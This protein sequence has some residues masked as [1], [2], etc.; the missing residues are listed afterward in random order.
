VRIGAGLLK[1][2]SAD[3]TL[4]PTLVVAEFESEAIALGRFQRLESALEISR[5][6]GIELLRRNSGGRAIRIGPGALGLL[7]SV[8]DPTAF[9]GAPVPPDKVINRFVRGLLAG[10]TRCG[11]PGGAH[12]FGR[13]FVSVQ[14]KQVA[15]VG[16][17]GS[18]R[19]ALFEAFVA[20]EQTLALPAGFN[21]Y[22]AHADPRAQGPE[23]VSLQVLRGKPVSFEAVAAAIV[24]GY[25]SHHRCELS[26]IDSAEMPESALDAAVEDEAGFSDSGV[27]EIPIGFLEA[28]VQAQA[29]KVQQARIRG[30]F[31][32]P[33]FAI[34]ELEKSL[35]DCPLS[36][37]ELGKRVDAAFHLPGA[38]VIGVQELRI[39][40]EAVLAAVQT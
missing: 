9:L 3:P 40:A 38:C 8:P 15:V 35:C 1:Q 29:D 32:A 16:Q 37:S 13:D 27:A 31:I 19:A 26:P 23:H 2:A 20:L 11:A 10:L 21:G 28:L 25:A 30:D 33:A 24:D 39:F 17:D 18:S 22:P 36:F 12:Y 7:L 4:A 6:E 5:V 34:R 14:S